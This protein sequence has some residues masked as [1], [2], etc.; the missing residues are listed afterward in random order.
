MR[1]ARRLFVLLSSLLVA[2]APA[3]AQGVSPDKRPTADLTAA[4]QIC[5][6]TARVPAG[7]TAR[8]IGR[9]ARD[10]FHA[11][12][13]HRIDSNGRLFSFGVTESEQEESPDKVETWRPG[14]LGWWQVLRYWRLLAQDKLPIDAAK[15]HLYLKGI[16]NASQMARDEGPV[17]PPGKLDLDRAL[18]A[19]ENVRP[20]FG[21]TRAE[22]E[23]M[24]QALIR[25]AINDVAW[26]AAF[27]S[28]VMR[29]AGVAAEAFQYDDAHATYI[30]AAFASTLAETRTAASEGERA[31]AR[32]ALYRACQP[33]VARPR[34]GDL[35]CYHRETKTHGGK[36][37]AVIRG[38]VIA[39]L[40]EGQ[41]RQ[42]IRRSHC[43]VVAHVD[44]ARSRVY[45]VG[46]NVQQA[47]SI[48]ALRLH[49]KRKTLLEVQP[50]RCTLDG[51]WTF[52]PPEPGKAIAPH[53]GTE[54]S[55]NAKGWFVLL[56][57][58]R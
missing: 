47:V 54:C 53:L 37:A 52:P 25:A 55:L 9:V 11:F 46:G 31:T 16:D 18:A 5:R 13:G 12:G 2:V 10:E 42:T 6:D 56:Q 29:Q 30:Y 1:P 20:Q 48:K 23:I 7:E 40:R 57:A 26:S 35:V 22:R 58:R 33:D 27:V 4:A 39:D 45:V 41:G 44:L 14:V 38:H 24:K 15:R 50:D 19:I 21:L 51:A 17:D 49:P 28:A 32:K 36:P 34:V 8:D 3:S 43:D